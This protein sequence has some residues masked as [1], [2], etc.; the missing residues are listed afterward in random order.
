MLREPVDPTPTKEQEREAIA[1]R[2]EADRERQLNPRVRVLYRSNGGDLLVRVPHEDYDSEGTARVYVNTM[3]RLHRPLPL[4]ALLEAG[5]GIWEK[6]DDE[7]LQLY[8][9]DR[10]D[11]YLEEAPVLMMG[12]G[13]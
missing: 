12:V 6:A 3:N 7:W 9:V 4:E 10:A 11:L 2:E 13:G 5:D 1:R 8:Q